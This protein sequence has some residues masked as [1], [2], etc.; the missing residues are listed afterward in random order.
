MAKGYPNTAN[1]RERRSTALRLLINQL[2]SGQKP[3]KVKR[4]GV[5]EEPYIPL[6][7]ADRKR[8]EQQIIT[9]KE[10]I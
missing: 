1:H 2:N 10:R 3:R 5:G 9:L 8:I 7:D 6:T 4:D